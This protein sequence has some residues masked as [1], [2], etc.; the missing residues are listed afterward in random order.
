MFTMNSVL[1]HDERTLLQSL[2]C[3]DKAQAIEVFEEI[4]MVIPVRSEMFANV[5]MLIDKLKNRSI[6]YNYEMTAVVG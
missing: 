1:T 2:G 3:R 5:V 4:K 6:D